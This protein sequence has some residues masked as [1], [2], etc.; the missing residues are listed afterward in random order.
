MFFL[1]PATEPSKEAVGESAAAEV[2]GWRKLL[3][4]DFIGSALVLALVT[5]LL[6]A[7]QWGE[8]DWLPV[9][10]FSD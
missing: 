6:L 4:M 3:K 5:C 1:L 8:C 9:A 10:R 2:Q 7:L